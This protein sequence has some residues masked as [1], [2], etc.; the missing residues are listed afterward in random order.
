MYNIDTGTALPVAL[1]ENRC[2]AAWKEQF[3]EE[4]EYLKTMG[5]IVTSTA[6]WAAPMFVVPKKNGSIRLVIDYRRLN[7]VIIPDP[8]PLPR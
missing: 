1:R 8:Y 7:K 2:P 6:P 5:F 3:Q 4:L